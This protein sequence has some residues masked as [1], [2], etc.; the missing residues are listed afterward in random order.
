MENLCSE[1]E[2]NQ[3]MS[4]FIKIVIGMKE[5][6]INFRTP[7][8]EMV[9][10]QNE[11]DLAYIDNRKVAL[12]KYE[13]DFWGD[14][15][16]ERLRGQNISD[17]VLYSNS[18]QFP[19]F[20][21][22]VRKN[23]EKLMG[24]TLLELK[25][26]ESGGISSFNSTIP[27]KYKTFEEIDKINGR[28]LV[29]RIAKIKDRD[30]SMHPDYSKF[31]RR[32]F[33]LVRTNKKKPDRIKVSIIDGSFF[34]TIPKKEVLSKM[35]QNILREH[36]DN[37]E[38]DLSN[39]MQKKVEEVFSHLTNQTLI[40]WSQPIEGASI[41][42]RLRVMAEVNKEGNPHNSKNYPEIV[43]GSVN[44]ILQSNDQI[45]NLKKFLSTKIPEIHICTIEHKNDGEYI[46]FQFNTINNPNR[47]LK[48][49]KL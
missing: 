7:L 32:C 43:E 22:K 17:I 21:Y 29:S 25:D 47:K 20:V 27:T 19:D 15:D 35:F 8:E 4:L 23:G 16:K 33:Y 40:A 31:D 38:F 10:R 26:S 28:N 12:D 11:N 45:Q 41:K 49:R 46:V 36:I 18:Q 42:P 30:I 39:E 1:G 34:E 48:Q 24:G 6:T 14:V 3:V 9:I 13:Y 37:K 5:K 2:F 44:L